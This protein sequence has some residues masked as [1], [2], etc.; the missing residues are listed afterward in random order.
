MPGNFPG[1][2][3]TLNELSLNEFEDHSGRPGLRG[4]SLPRS[5]I[6]GLTMKVIRQQASLQGKSVDQIIHE[7]KNGEFT[8]VSG[9]GRQSG[10]PRTAYAPPPPVLS[11]EEIG[12]R[13]HYA[14][15]SSDPHT[16][17]KAKSVQAL[18]KSSDEDIRHIGRRRLADL[19]KPSREQLEQAQSEALNPFHGVP[20][21]KEGE[22]FAGHALRAFTYAVESLDKPG[23]AVRGVI[24]G[25]YREGLNIVPFS[26]TLGITKS[27][28]Q[29]SGRDL[30][31]KIGIVGPN[32]E[33]F[34]WGDV[35]G[36]IVEGLT[37][38]LMYVG[39]IGA[40]SKSA[41]M[42]LKGT[43]K[44]TA[45][46]LAK[47]AETAAKA[48]RKG[49][50]AYKLAEAA[51]RQKIIAAKVRYAKRAKPLQ[52]GASKA[53]K[54]RMT[55]AQAQAAA[56][57]AQQVLKAGGRVNPSAALMM[58]LKAI[59]KSPVGGELFRRLRTYVSTKA[60][61]AIR[62]ATLTEVPKTVKV[63]GKEIKTGVTR[64]GTTVGHLLRKAN[65]KVT[66]SKTVKQTVAKSRELA[67]YLNEAH[68]AGD[69]F[70]QA[71]GVREEKERK[72]RERNATTNSVLVA[73]FYGGV[74]QAKYQGKDYIVAPLSLIVEGVLN[75]SK[76]ALHYPMSEMRRSC[77]LWNGT[78]IVVYHPTDPFGR[79]Q[80]AKNN[81]DVL[82]RSGIGVVRNARIAGNKLV[83]E[84]WFEVDRT[85][86]VD[87]RVYNALIN[88][89]KMELST[90]LDTVN[91][92][93]AGVWNGRNYEKIARNYKPDHLAIL[94]DQIGACS[95]Q[96]GCGVMVANRHVTTLGMIVNMRRK[97]RRSTNVIDLRTKDG[98]PTYPTGV[99]GAVVKARRKVNVPK[100]DTEI[101]QT[102]S[103]PPKVSMRK[104]PAT[105]DSYRSLAPADP[106]T[107]KLPANF[108]SRE[109]SEEV[110][111]RVRKGIVP[112]R[113]SEGRAT[114]NMVTNCSC[115]NTCQACQTRNAYTIN[116]FVS[117]AQRRYMYA[118]HPK[119]AKRWSAEMKKKGEPAVQP[120]KKKKESVQ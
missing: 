19:P 2:S 87:S 120:D 14:L 27:D 108:G 73:N 109:I 69:A 4:G 76:G 48:G 61:K 46:Q 57:Q 7:A 119:I 33:G 60:G 3:L 106:H 41:S 62:K 79:P 58:M 92:P 56:A 13:L 17:I 39:G 72:R 105:L 37:D 54:A 103:K 65:R 77:Q 67:R 10:S 12:H 84:G 111:S 18:L 70:L 9:G 85:R 55:K 118:K 22:S 91:E 117:E 68:I 26:D 97:G 32:I 21:K 6:P 1:M 31:E 47:V 42:S 34:D 112:Q 100:H 75:G 23:R 51:E 88:Q 64:K 16:Q 63:L 113:T 101:A 98:S 114:W 52:F 25:K 15:R 90:G 66:G 35:G 11:D 5:G 89:Q 78:P 93:K 50:K 43:Q 116:P 99:G 110:D 81:P 40:V 86:K 38:P 74:R 24:G 95:V 96:D 71:A 102:D 82:N 80:R 20:E 83:A 59:E 29:V 44:L 45:K 8:P 49:S 104:P 107:G 115:N 36:L 94:P 28:Q 53:T 30:L